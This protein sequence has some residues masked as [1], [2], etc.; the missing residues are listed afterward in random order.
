[1]ALL[2]VVGLEDAATRRAGAYSKGMSQRL[3]L[4]RSMIN[5]PS[6]WFLDEPASGQDPA[7]TQRVK[8]IVREERERGV[9]VFLTTHNMQVAEDLCDR[10]AF[11]NE[12]KSVDLDTPRGLKP[13]APLQVVALTVSGALLA[14]RVG[15]GRALRGDR[16]RRQPALLRGLLVLVQP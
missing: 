8:D 14:S 16:F 4:A 2:R 13:F 5:R 10:V 6:I 15:R 12:V 3:V 11:I 1:M 7:M 9:T